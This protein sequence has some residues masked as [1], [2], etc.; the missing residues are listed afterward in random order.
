MTAVAFSADVLTIDAAQVAAEIESAMREIVLTRLKRK[1]VVLGLS[2]GIDSSVTAALCVRALGA[3]RVVGLFMP[4]ADSSGDSLRLG[5]RVADAL[6]I[7]TY[8]EDITAILEGAGCYRRRDDA[9][10]SVVPGYDDGFKCKLVQTNVVE[11]AGYPV[12]YVVVRS[13][14]GTEQKVRLTAD[15]CLGVVAASNFKQRARKMME[16]YYAD[17]YQ[18]AVVGT[19]NIL[20]YDQGFFVKNGDG[21]AD[22][23]PI[24]HLYKSQ[25]YQLAEY[26]QIDEEI[27]RRPPTTDTYPLEQTQEEFYFSLSLRK[28]D[29]CLYGRNH[30]VPAEQV[31]ETTGLTQSQ[32]E[33]VYAL[34]DSKRAA[35]RYLHAPPL[36]V[37]SHNE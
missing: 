22:V 13:P 15:A 34:I 31:A 36:L 32:V 27:Q 16:Y 29:L 24:A 3:N 1:G 19:P 17:R 20:E 28:T 23:K 11:Q 12:F 30:H 33:R 18:L 5:Q 25:I 2:G 26:L 8:L 9:I 37:G 14:D 35:A 6:G 4:E 7:R 10:R 21:S